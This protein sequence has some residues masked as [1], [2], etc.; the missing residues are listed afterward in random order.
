M[1]DAKDSVALGLLPW[2]PCGSAMRPSTIRLW[3]WA[4]GMKSG[5]GLSAT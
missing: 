5:S 4:G 2:W 1:T 3:A